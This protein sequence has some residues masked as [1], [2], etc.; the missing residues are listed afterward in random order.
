[1]RFQE[2][3]EMAIL[4]YIKQNNIYFFLT[5]LVKIIIIII[6]LFYWV[7]FKAHM[8]TVQHIKKVTVKTTGNGG[9][10]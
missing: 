9:M 4:H 2:L 3:N 6:H 10:Q 7:P 1:M 5:I 8:V